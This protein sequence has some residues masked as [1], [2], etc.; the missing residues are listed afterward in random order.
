MAYSLTPRHKHNIHKNHDTKKQKQKRCTS[1]GSLRVRPPQISQ[2]RP[3]LFSS[4]LFIFILQ[5][6]FSLKEQNNMK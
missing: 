3:H 2:Y 5:I 6:E 4:I 1:S